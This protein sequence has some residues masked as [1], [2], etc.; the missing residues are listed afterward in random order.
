MVEDG[1]IKDASQKLGG[2]EKK[3]LFDPLVKFIY[4]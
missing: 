1:H 2:G 3:T 4:F